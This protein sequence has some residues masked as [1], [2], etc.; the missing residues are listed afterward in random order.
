MSLV[1]GVDTDLQKIPFCRSLLPHHMLLNLYGNTLTDPYLDLFE[2]YDL[3]LTP[4]EVI[5]ILM[6]M[7]VEM[8]NGGNY[9]QALWIDSQK[10]QELRLFVSDL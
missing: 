6:R 9:W 7:L 1:L 4:S 5:L 3:S 2:F 10:P 8:D